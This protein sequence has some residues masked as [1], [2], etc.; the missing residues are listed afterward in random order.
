MIADP[1]SMSSL[2]GSIKKNTGFIKKL[3][4]GVIASNVESLKKECLSLKLQKYI[5]E[6]ASTLGDGMPKNASDVMAVVELASLLYTRF[7]GFLEGFTSGL[8]KQFQSRCTPPSVG[9]G[10]NTTATDAS[11][12]EEN[13]RISTLRSSLRMLTELYLVG[14]TDDDLVPKAG[15]QQPKSFIPYLL[16]AMVS[17]F[18]CDMP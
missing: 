4:S 5:E 18:V 13:M 2:D 16:F 7:D 3:K 1:S 15:P 11:E 14:L 9:S 12:K 6:V 8:M 17:E 10:T